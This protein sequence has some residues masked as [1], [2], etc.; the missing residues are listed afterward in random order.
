MAG[1]KLS[2]GAKKRIEKIKEQESLEVRIICELEENE[3]IRQYLKPYDEFNRDI[4]L[5]T[6]AHHKF[7]WIQYADSY[8]RQAESD[9]LEYRPDAE[10]C[11]WEIQQ[12]KLFDLQCRWRAGEIALEGVQ[13]TID[14]LHWERDIKLCPCL[15]PITEVEVDMYIS[16]LE[17]TN[18][19]PRHGLISWQEYHTFKKEYQ[20]ETGGLMPDWYEFHNSHTG[21]GTLLILPDLKGEAEDRYIKAVRE[22]EAKE[23]KKAG[24]YEEPKPYV[25]KPG[26]SAYNPEDVEAFARKFESKADYTRYLHYR[27]AKDKEDLN[28][29]I[30]AELRILQNSTEPI[31]IESHSDWR[32][33]IQLAANAYKNRMVIRAMPGV[34]EDYLFKRQTGISYETTRSSEKRK[35]MKIYKQQ[36]LKGRKLLGEPENFDY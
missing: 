23:K 16:Y 2:K 12:K 8:E 1:N 35:W 6:Y 19:S 27:N 24:T 9:A 32:E 17:S 15:E 29:T 5:K 10:E 3:E 11:L 30:E 34:Y 33:A 28:E 7:M 25:P 22:Q 21:N 26:I 4:F 31:P 13:A 20:D 18:T 36:I 14:F